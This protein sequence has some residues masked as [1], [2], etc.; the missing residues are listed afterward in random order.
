MKKIK[1]YLNRGISPIIAILIIVIIGIA[2]VGGV[3]AYQY[4]W[5][6]E[7]PQHQSTVPVI[8]DETAAW[9]TYRNEEY[10]FEIKYPNDFLYQD[11]VAK[12]LT[13]RF[14][15]CPYINRDGK[16][17]ENPKESDLRQN[18]VSKMNEKKTNDF[19]YCYVAMED[20]GMS[21]VYI[22]HYIYTKI[23]T[24]LTFISHLTNCDVYDLN[25][26]SH[27]DCVLY[28]DKYPQVINQILSTFKKS[29]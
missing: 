7:E 14:D 4:Y 26:S 24:G 15:K 21:Q 2:V 17:I 29:I 28:R 22:S 16:I 18:F 25:D 13:A 27:N 3:L 6:P 9:Q 20:P 11:P 1:Q 19:S 23:G 10:G 12:E 8:K 5:Q